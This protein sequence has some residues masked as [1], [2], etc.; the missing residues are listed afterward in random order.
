RRVL[1]ELAD[2]IV[3]NEKKKPE[4][5][6]VLVIRT[7]EA[8]NHRGQF[9]ARTRFSFRE[10]L[11]PSGELDVAPLEHLPYQLLL[12]GE[13]PIERALGHLQRPG[14]VS[15]RRIG[16]PLVDEQLNG[17]GLDAVACVS[18]SMSWHSE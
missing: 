15:D 8:A 1:G 17:G 13:V 10:F 11:E 14:D 2:L 12:A 7:A 3:L 16:D 4:E 9:S 18:E 6:G 5:P